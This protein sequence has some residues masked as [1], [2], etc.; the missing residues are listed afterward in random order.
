M[1]NP[2]GLLTGHDTFIAS[3]G[4]LG[5]D[6]EDAVRIIQNMREPVPATPPPAY[7][8]PA[9]RL[10]NAV[11]DGWTFCSNNLLAV[12]LP[13][14]LLG[15]PAILISALHNQKAGELIEFLLGIVPL[16]GIIRMV[17]LE[18]EQGA[19]PSVSTCLKEG[20]AYYGRGLFGIIATLLV[21]V[22]IIIPLALGFY[23][24]DNTAQH[25]AG[26]CYLVLLGIPALWFLFFGALRMTVALPAIADTKN[27]WAYAFGASIRLTKGRTVALFWMLFQL[28]LCVGILGI[29]NQSIIEFAGQNLVQS[30]PYEALLLVL[31]SLC[32]PLYILK[33]WSAA[34]L[35]KAYLAIKP[36][37]VA[38]DGRV[39][40]KLTLDS[41]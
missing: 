23:L 14:F 9:G 39:R 17:L 25:A 30:L 27:S 7:P 22:A 11:E 41:V 6:E 16:M 34:T 1:A 4:V 31:I 21:V 36:R 15:I 29:V 19:R 3:S 8:L 40:E 12:S 13:G 5:I 37:A 20:F 18:Q 32:Y 10:G 35:A 24:M 33:A 38:G 28:G 2:I 26:V